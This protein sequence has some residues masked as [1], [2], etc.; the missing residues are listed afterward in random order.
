MKII[1]EMSVELESRSVNEAFARTA[2]S[3][4]VSQLDPTVG[5][6]ND[7]RTAV[8]EAVT[9]CVVHAYRDTIGLIRINVK[10][11]ADH[12]VIIRIRDNGVGIEDVHQAME[13]LYTTASSEERAGLGFA[14]MQSFSDDVKVRSSLSRG[15]TITL[16][17]KLS[18]RISDV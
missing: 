1:N 2:V 9:N 5:E 15:T 14:V 13:P 3:S 7:I 6:L 4:F 10:L 12:T 8:S 17:K 16:T 18:P 11:A